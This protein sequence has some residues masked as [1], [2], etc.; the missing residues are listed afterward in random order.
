MKLIISK[1]TL[2]LLSLLLYN[3]IVLSA[4]NASIIIYNANLLTMSSKGDIKN[5][6]VVIKGDKIISVGDSRLLKDYKAATKINAHNNIV[7]PG[8]INTHTHI[9]MI[10]F[11]SLGE[12]GIKNRLFGCFFPLEHRYVT[13]KLVYLA[14]LHG[15][16]EMVMGGVTAYADMY[17]F[18]N[19]EARAAKKIGIRGVIGETIINMT[20]PD[21]KTP[22]ES[23]KKAISFI[24]QYHNDP[25]IIPAFAPHTLYT[26]GVKELKKIAQLSRKLKVRILIHLAE[27]PHNQNKYYKK[28]NVYFLQQVGMLNKYVTVAHAIHI[29]SK[30]IKLLAQHNVGVS[31]NPMA[32]AKGATGIADA[33]QMLK[34]GVSV[35]LGTDGPM[36]SNQ[37]TIIPIMSYAANMQR[38]LYMNRT[39][40]LPKQIVYM[41]TLGGAKALH[42]D[43][44]VGSIKVGKRA[45]IIIIDTK[46][47][48]MQPHFDPYAALVFQANPENVDTTII[49]G[50]IIMLH[51]KL[52]TYSLTK[53]AHD[54]SALYKKI[55]S[56]FCAGK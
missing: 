52:M 53:D 2:V 15:D 48:N 32:N 41:A 4:N 25:L 16:I 36:S 20:A 10:A 8:M 31:Y 44:L 13:P 7:M 5:G 40:M 26:L 24:K 1:S 3:S 50:K 34:S 23:I 22:Q 55:S 38:I 45:D 35:G 9:P 51:R 14:S 54:M 49:N 28:D 29:D 27:I 39:I 19:Q 33:Y 46:A 56:G 12:E 42:I 6:V 43:K 30:Q 11:R 17:Y 18:V 21:A 47:P 37:L